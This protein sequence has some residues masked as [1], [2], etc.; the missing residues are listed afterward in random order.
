VLV[1]SGYVEGIGLTD[2]YTHALEQRAHRRGVELIWAGERVKHSRGRTD[3]GQKIYSLWDSYVQADMVTYPSI[4]EGWGN[5]FIEAVFAHLPVVL[6]EYPVWRSDLAQIGFDVA[7]LGD[8]IVAYDEHGLVE[9]ADE[10]L[11][12]AVEH[13]LKFLKD[14]DRRRQATELNYDLAQRFFSYDAL[15][16]YI[17]PLVDRALGT[18]GV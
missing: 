16:S 14:G 2:T 10:Q 6:F 18:Q 3:D 4:W 8:Q 1:C 17:M 13:T 7:S 5:Q 9:V 12:R 15:E 11:D